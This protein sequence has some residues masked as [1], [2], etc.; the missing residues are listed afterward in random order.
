MK[1][2]FAIS[3]VREKVIRKGLILLKQGTRYLFSFKNSLIMLLVAHHA[4]QAYGPGGL[5]Y[6]QEGESADWL[7]KFFAVN[8]ALFMKL[9]SCCRIRHLSSAS[10]SA[11]PLPE[12]SFEEYD[13]NGSL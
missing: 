8:A 4:G 12:D 11:I 7:R 6:F 1:E 2:K 3:F 13:V 5:W 10:S 9:F